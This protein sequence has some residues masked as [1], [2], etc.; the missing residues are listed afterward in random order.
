M[1]PAKQE[2][3][4]SKWTGCEY[5]TCKLAKLGSPLLIAQ[6]CLVAHILKLLISFN[7]IMQPPSSYLE[8]ASHLELFY[9]IIPF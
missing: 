2:S 5:S 9:R 1:E 7:L 6:F 4:S 3:G 8:V